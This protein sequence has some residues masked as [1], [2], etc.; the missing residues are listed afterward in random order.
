MNFFRH[1]RTSQAI[2][3]AM[4]VSAPGTLAWSKT[5]CTR[6]TEQDC[7]I[8]RIYCGVDVRR[9]DFAWSVSIQ[10]KHGDFRWVHS[11]TGSLVQ[12]LI[13]NGKLEGWRSSPDEPEWLITA[14]HCLVDKQG[15]FVD[16]SKRRIIA[17]QNS[18]E[19]SDDAVWTREI[20][21]Y[22]VNPKYGVKTYDSDIAVVRLKKSDQIPVREADAHIS[23]VT[24]ADR[25]IPQFQATTAPYASTFVSGWGF[26][27]KGKEIPCVQQYLQQP[28]VEIQYCKQAASENGYPVPDGA[29]CAGFSTGVFGDCN[30]DSGGGLVHVPA[31]L[32][33]APQSL[34]LGVVSSSRISNGACAIG[35]NNFNFYADVADHHAWIVE[36]VTAMH[37]GGA[38]ESCY[39]EP[40]K[41]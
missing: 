11:C 34:L 5:L 2:A 13:R 6:M 17:G 16:V 3:L 26:M 30:G 18:I 14:G 12:P 40:G 37:E 19:A 4:S 41:G 8:Q 38:A 25:S 32:S 21:D 39:R 9:G 1:L 10:N 15:L 23:A 27:R 36:T 7:G 28:M 22:C 24:P 29:I 31:G 20:Q 33:D 35:N